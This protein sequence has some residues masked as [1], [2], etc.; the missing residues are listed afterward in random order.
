MAM[1]NTKGRLGYL[2]AEQTQI[3]EQFKKEL[4]AESL[5]DKEIHSD[6]HLL[7]FLR[8]RQ[9]QLPAAKEMWSNCEK[10]RKEFGTN[11]VEFF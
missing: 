3:L 5:Y 11:T 4:E 9:F 10:W 2:T 7:R 8:A 1:E 6:H